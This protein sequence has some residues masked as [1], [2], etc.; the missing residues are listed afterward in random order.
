M[1]FG[2]SKHVLSGWLDR[3]APRRCAMCTATLEPG[4]RAGFCIGCLLAMPGAATHRCPV[5]AMPIPRG[6]PSCTACQSEPPPYDATLAAA[7]YA[8]PLDRIVT[9]LKFGRQIALA[10]PLGEL[11]ATRWLGSLTDTGC[12]ALVDRL[13]PIPLGPSR[14]A[15]RGFNQSLEMARAC[16]AAL[17]GRRGSGRMPPVGPSLLRRIRDTATQ[18]ALDLEARSRNLEGCFMC[19]DRLDG[20]H[21]ALVDDVMTT[22]NTLAEA[23]RTLKRAGAASVINLVVARTG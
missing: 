19:P 15:R 13:V 23:A 22:G 7:D 2:W 8:P 21:I 5:C 11:I 3:L 16:S 10:R 18:T 17:A 6:T 1:V 4:A 14:L 9:A 12:P 20:L